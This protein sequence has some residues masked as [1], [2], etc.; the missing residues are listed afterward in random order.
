MAQLTTLTITE[1]C[2]Q[3]GVLEDELQEIVGLGIVKPLQVQSE[4]WLFDDAAVIIVHRAVKL[5][6]ELEID[7]PGIAFA[8]NLLDENEKLKHE[9]GQLR[10][11][12]TRF[13]NE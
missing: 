11:Q 3:T 9:N 6:H 12:L 7:W 1:F 10:L 4:C 13:I 2:F 5:Y 8:M